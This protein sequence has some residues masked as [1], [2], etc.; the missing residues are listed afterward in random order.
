VPH[1]SKAPA[2]AGA[3]LFFGHGPVN[4]WL[5]TTQI[6]A[7]SLTSCPAAA[8]ARSMRGPKKSASLETRTKSLRERVC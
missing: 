7:T 3:Y 8:R 1:L 6:L 5:L 4:N 2:V